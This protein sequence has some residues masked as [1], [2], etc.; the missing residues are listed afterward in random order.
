MKLRIRTTILQLTLFGFLLAVLPLIAALVHS[1]LRI[2]DLSAKMTSI[3]VDTNETVQSSRILLSQILSLERSAA[4]FLVLRDRS[5]L[6]IYEE[7]RPPFL[8]TTQTLTGIVQAEGT[9]KR[10]DEIK[11]RER[12]VYRALLTQSSLPEDSPGDPF[13]LPPFSELARPVPFEVSQQVTA[14][15]IRIQDQITN[16][17]QLLLLQAL[18]L[19]PSALLMAIAF[20]IFITRPL[21]E[22]GSAVRR[23]GSGDF[24]GEVRVRG[25]QDIREI[26]RRMDALRVHLNELE[27]QKTMFLQHVSHELKTPLTAIR[28]GV[29]LL[30]DEVVGKLTRDQAEVAGILRASS[31]QLQKQIEDLLKF[32][33]VLGQLS[34]R[35]VQSVDFRSLTE[36]SIASQRLFS[37]SRQV[38]IT[39]DLDDATVLGDPE[40]LRAVVDNLL[41][42]AIS[43]SP[44]ASFVNVALC[45]RDGRAILDVQDQ[46][47]GIDPGDRAHVFEAFY[48]GKRRRRGHVKGT[49]LGLA[50]C[51]RYTD[52]H[53]GTIEIIDASEGAHFRLSIPLGTQE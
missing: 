13:S 37:L 27:T 7:Q 4:Q 2:G 49:G 15:A 23:L 22:I 14:D 8:E 26:S 21:K 40:Q 50:I 41:S 35:S 43:Y 17:R 32:N 53:Q 19:I 24:S 31:H 36:E 30:S 44:D 9:L 34:L 25:P 46:G 33:T 52:L 16:V 5:L 11:D 6:D 29:E 51:E 47:P 39:K 45:V 48:Q 3:L 1:M 20:S 18:A 28:E 12:E 42:N 38:D 10:L